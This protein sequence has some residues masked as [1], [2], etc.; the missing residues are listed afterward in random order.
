MKGS[1][2]IRIFLSFGWYSRSRAP[3]LLG[4]YILDYLSSNSASRLAISSHGYS[5]SDQ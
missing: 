4:D 2:S 3:V 5:A 1:F